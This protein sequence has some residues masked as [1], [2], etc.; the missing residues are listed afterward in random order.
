MTKGRTG[1]STSLLLRTAVQ[2]LITAVV[3]GDLVQQGVGA[4]VEVLKG[5]GVTLEVRL[6]PSL[7]LPLGSGSACWV[8]RE[9]QVG[10][11]PQVWYPFRN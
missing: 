3:T 7:L 8:C 5:V 4:A 6:R 2:S 11:E 10:R 9:P 1:H